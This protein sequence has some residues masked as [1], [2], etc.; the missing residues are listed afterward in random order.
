[1]RELGSKFDRMSD[2]ERALVFE[3][4]DLTLDLMQKCISDKNRL[5]EIW[6]NLKKTPA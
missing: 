3:V 6:N 1:M 4:I 2:F 5:H